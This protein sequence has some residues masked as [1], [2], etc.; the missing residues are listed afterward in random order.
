MSFHRD[1]V[2]RLTDLQ[3]LVSKASAYKKGYLEDDYLESIIPVYTATNSRL[4]SKFESKLPVI[5]IG[6]YLFICIDS[7]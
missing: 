1:K 7:F 4:S 6:M 5:N 3:A 2:I